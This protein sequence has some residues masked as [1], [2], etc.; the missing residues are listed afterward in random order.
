MKAPAQTP[1]QISPLAEK[2]LAALKD[3][4]KNCVE[5]DCGGFTTD[6]MQWRMGTA[7]LSDDELF[8]ALDELISN[9]LIRFSGFDDEDAIGSCYALKEGGSL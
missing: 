7:F 9:D 2:M 6:D 1:K 3:L 8:K 4:T 5:H